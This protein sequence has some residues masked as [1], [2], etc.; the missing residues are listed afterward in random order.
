MRLTPPWWDRRTAAPRSIDATQHLTLARRIV[1]LGVWSAATTAP[2]TAGAFFLPPYGNPRVWCDLPAS[3][4][5]PP[6]SV[7]DIHGGL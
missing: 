2:A 6:C 7:F 5:L 1:V 3:L 4:V